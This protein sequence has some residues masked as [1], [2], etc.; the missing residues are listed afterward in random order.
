METFIKLQNILLPR[1][2]VCTEAGLYYHSEREDA[3]TADASSG[4]ICFRQEGA[5][6]LAVGPPTSDT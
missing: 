3:L 4:Q 5:R 1:E 6:K 2:G